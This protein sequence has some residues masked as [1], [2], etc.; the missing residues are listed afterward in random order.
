M[1]KSSSNDGFRCFQNQVHLENSGSTAKNSF[2]LTRQP[3]PPTESVRGSSTNFPFLP[4]GFENLESDESVKDDTSN[5][6]NLESGAVFHFFDIHRNIFLELV[7]SD[8]TVVGQNF[9]F[10]VCKSVTILAFEE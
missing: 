6:L 8:W 10:C 7:F 9:V 3:G 4:G 2:S 5:A 1:S